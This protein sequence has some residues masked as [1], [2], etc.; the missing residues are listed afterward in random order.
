MSTFGRIH[1][2]VRSACE[3]LEQAVENHIW[4]DKLGISDPQFV[5]PNVVFDSQSHF[6]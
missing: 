4:D 2:H 1:F 3:S 5:V 6:L